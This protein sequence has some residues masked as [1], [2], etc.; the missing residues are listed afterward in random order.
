MTRAFD[1]LNELKQKIATIREAV[2]FLL[3]GD[4]IIATQMF[5]RQSIWKGVGGGSGKVTFTTDNAGQP[6]HNVTKAMVIGNANASLTGFVGAIGKTLADLQSVYLDYTQF[7]ANMK[8]AVASSDQGIW[9]YGEAP[10][11]YQ[12]QSDGQ[13]IGSASITPHPVASRIDVEVNIDDIKDYALTDGVNPP[14]DTQ[15]DDYYSMKFDSV[16]ILYGAKYTALVPDFA[17]T[18]AAL[19]SQVTLGNPPVYMVSGTM[20]W[21]NSSA[22]YPVV[23]PHTEYH[24]TDWNNAAFGKYLED[25]GESGKTTI[26]RKSL[27]GLAPLFGYDRHAILVLYGDMY[28]NGDLRNHTGKPMRRFF[29]VHFS[30]D[31]TDSEYL[32][33]G[34]AYKVSITF[35]DGAGSA[36]G[37]DNNYDF[38]HSDSGNTP[39]TDNPEEITRNPNISIVV[40][41]TY[42]KAYVEIRKDF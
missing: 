10:V 2:V 24:L 26:F 9:I 12:Q 34:K 23:S 14:A 20:P 7:D 15:Y 41:N 4:E 32:A 5:D 1:D 21:E 13:A 28:K 35:G 39:G 30:P 25:T 16:A 6:L 3:E 27:Y 38:G 33:N 42:W 8:A 18:V 37:S 31:E 22:W 11:Q 17:P 29:P 40:N 36:D 19:A